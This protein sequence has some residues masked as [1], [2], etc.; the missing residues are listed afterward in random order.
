MRFKLHPKKSAATPD[1]PTD[2]LDFA[3]R[4]VA[5]FCKMS[6]PAHSRYN[7]AKD[8]LEDLLVKV[9]ELRKEMLQ[10]AASAPSRDH[11][12]G[13]IGTLTCAEWTEAKIEAALGLQYGDMFLDTTPCALPPAP[14]PL[15]GLCL[16]RATQEDQ[17]M[18]VMRGTPPA[19]TFGEIL[20]RFK[21]KH[22]SKITNHPLSKT[23]ARLIE[24]G[25]VEKFG[26]ARGATYSVRGA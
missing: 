2:V 3:D 20:R 24:Q 5:R 18:S 23:L 9:E 17:V 7:S 22:G 12:V 21:R 4:M 8:E 11:V 14:E 15:T 25:R 6:F 19:V 26:N 1:E 16:R 13:I 10:L